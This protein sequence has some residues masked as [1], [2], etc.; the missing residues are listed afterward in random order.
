MCIFSGNK[1]ERR[2]KKS[3]I[4][5]GQ[6]SH[7]RLFKDRQV[8]RICTCI[9]KILLLVSSHWACSRQG[10]SPKVA[11]VKDERCVG[12]IFHPREI[13][14]RKSG[15]SEQEGERRDGARTKEAKW[16][17]E[18]KREKKEEGKKRERERNI[19]KC[20]EGWKSLV[21]PRRWC[22]RSYKFCLRLQCMHPL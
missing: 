22:V 20:W 12:L 17:R 13:E 9:Q 15:G 5:Y 8:N 21:C 4:V 16:Y 11:L 6:W 18:E 3:A 19:H 14:N 7:F 1:S 10:M 2:Y